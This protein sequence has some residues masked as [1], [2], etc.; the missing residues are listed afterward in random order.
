M[1]KSRVGMPRIRFTGQ[2]ID[3]PAEARK[4]RRRLYPATILYSAYALT[5]LASALRAAQSPLVP[6]AFFS[7]GVAVWTFIEYLAHRFILHQRFP[8]GPG[9]FQHWLHRTFD[10]LH[11]EHHARPWDGNHISGTIKDT[12]LY[13]AFFAALSFLAP[14]HTAPVFWAGIMQSYVVEEWVHQSVHYLFLYK[15]GGPYWRYINCHHCYHHS[16]GGSE[17]AFG[18]TN[19]FWDIAFR[20]RVP[21]RERR[22]MYGL[23]SARRSGTTLAG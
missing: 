20:T 17:L 21:E 18:L 19:E 9:I 1:L 3:L 14:I 5:V 12:V 2:R 4:A 8:D 6:L 16:P 22:L 11:T 13:M 15:L 10:N 23:R 7:A